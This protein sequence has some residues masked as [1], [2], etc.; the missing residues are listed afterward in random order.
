MAPS[1]SSG[2]ASAV[3]IRLGGLSGGDLRHIERR[4]HFRVSPRFFFGREV[5]FVGESAA[6]AL[7][8]DECRTQNRTPILQ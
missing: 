8:D 4:D 2:L 7:E 5:E 6:V 3:L 1:V